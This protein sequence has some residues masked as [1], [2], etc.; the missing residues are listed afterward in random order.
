V[1][2]LRPLVESLGRPPPIYL[3]VGSE[4][5][6]V[7][8]GLEA[9]RD[10]LL[11][12]PMARLNHASF[13]ASDEAARAF[14]QTCLTAPMMA[15]RRVVEITQVQDANVALLDALLAY[16][17]APCPSAVLV[18]SGER[19]PPA[20]GGTDRGARLSNAV[21]KVGLVLK[22]DGEGVDPLGFAA[23]HA[24]SLGVTIDRGAAG[25][26]VA[27][28]GGELSAIAG[29]VQRCADFVGAGGCITP[30]VVNEV[31]VLT[32]DASV[33]ALTDAILAR[34]RG[35]A[36]D[37]AH[38]LLQEGEPPLK[39]FGSIA[40]QLRQVLLVQDAVHRGVS[41]AEAGVRMPPFKLRALREAI[42]RHPLDAAAILHDLAAANQ[43][44]NSSRAGD[45]RVFE[46][47]VLRLVA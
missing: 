35:A 3:V 43:G 13:G 10:G 11:V 36:L 47:L 1:T 34:D 26:L 9:L 46:A 33:W 42:Q 38:R 40:W 37:T 29:D 18:V 41:E 22:L 14:A 5:L 44:M 2:P 45:R 30:S 7:R 20:V 12:G 31:C 4:A 21:K 24:R 39:L 19:L 15:P 27:L 6:L 28:A 8:R 17:A 23:E 32:A 16:A 25:E